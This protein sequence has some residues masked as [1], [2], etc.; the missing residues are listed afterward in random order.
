MIVTGHMNFFDVEQ[1]GLFKNGTEKSFGL[2]MAETFQ[3]IANWVGERPMSDTLPWEMSKRVDGVKCFC[4]DIYKCE[5]TGDFLFVLWKSGTD[6]NGSLLGAEEDK[7][8]GE[9]AVIE[10]TNAYKGK[11]LIWG[12]P[13]YYWVIPSLKT[14]V[15]IKFE[16]S[17]CDSQLFQDWVSACVVNRIQHPNKRKEY[18]DRNFARLYF[19]DGTQ[20]SA[21]R[22]RYSFNMG[23]KSLD[24]A[25]AKLRELASKITHIIKRETIE[26]RPKDERSQW[27]KRFDTIPYLA[28]KKKSI[29]RQIEIKAE[30][31]PT[32]AEVKE[33]IERFAQE[34]R[35]Q[36]DWDNVGFE[37][38]TSGTVW[39]DR[40]RMKSSVNFDL[41]KNV[42][43]ALDLFER[44]N[45]RRKEHLLPIERA[46][47]A[48]KRRVRAQPSTL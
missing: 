47:S 6:S 19:T 7:S 20:D 12:R 18:T 28:P 26:V 36:G 46:N 21:T 23:L 13:C 8:A 39:V 24:T 34:N 22:F 1:C 5:D 40:Y 17:V 44:L 30:A 16:H 25:N 32:A 37:T 29:K 48:P 45:A 41:K 33:I 11:S 27:V 10:Y 35:K 43:P 15:S 31:R 3:L 9:S 38:E 42:I 2:D 4:H 14:I